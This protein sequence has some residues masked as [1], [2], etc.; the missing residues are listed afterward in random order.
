MREDQFLSHSHSIHYTVIDHKCQDNYAT[1]SII[2]LS[3][4]R[5]IILD[6]MCL[7]KAFAI[8]PLVIELS[9]S[10]SSASVLIFPVGMTKYSS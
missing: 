5:L 6:L 4:T 1:F 7:V 3:N 2:L 10:S 8:L 9:T